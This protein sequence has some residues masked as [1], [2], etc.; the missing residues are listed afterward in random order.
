M[1]N[2]HVENLE[3]E[4]GVTDETGQKEVK[5]VV[6]RELRFS[7]LGKDNVESSGCL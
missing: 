4:Q 2:Y 5:I 3:V 7:F 6:L 1:L